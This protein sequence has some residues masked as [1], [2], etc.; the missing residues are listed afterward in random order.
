MVD[1]PLHTVVETPTYLAAV[2]KVGLSPAERDAV[3]DQ[4]MRDPSA[5]DL[6]RNSGGVRKVRVARDDGGKSGGYRVLSYFMDM[7][8]P[9]FLLF[10]IDKTSIDNITAKQTTIL[11]AMAKQIKAE[12]NAGTA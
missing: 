8:A 7:D 10:V 5:G 11:R 12:R 2:R 1:A 9:V 4:V 3:L 6:I